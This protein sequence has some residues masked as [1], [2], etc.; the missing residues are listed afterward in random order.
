MN[1]CACDPSKVECKNNVKEILIKSQKPK[2]EKINMKKIFLM[3]D[4]QSRK[5]K[6]KGRKS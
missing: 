2:R 1:V 5:F 6:D 3:Y 4:K